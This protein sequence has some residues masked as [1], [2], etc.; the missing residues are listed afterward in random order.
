LL[1]HTPVRDGAAKGK[2]ERFFRTTR[3]QFLSRQLD[4]SSL[5]ALNRQFIQWVEENYNAQLHS[6]LGMSP[7]DR[8]ALDR[9]RVRFLPPNQ[10][11]DELFFVEED[12][13][14]NHN[15]VLLGQPPLL[16]SLAL[17]IN[18]EIRSRITYSVMMPRLGPEDTAAFIFT[19]LD[20]AGLGH[21]TFTQDALALVV[22]S[23][24]GL[25]RR[26]RNLCL[27]AL[28]EAVR[29]QT[30]IVDLKQVN[31]VLIQPH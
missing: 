12:F 26:T 1:A 3:D 8:F 28:I 7:L 21:N 6:V 13:P 10:A 17:T 20:R 24:E 18:E 16:Q 27:A 30:R 11:N 23:A 19:Q 9:S 25:L 22:R 29:D 5:E 4:L 14:R 2:V 31:H 15:L